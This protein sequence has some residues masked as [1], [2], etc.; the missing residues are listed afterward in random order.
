[1]AG[2]AR[3]S[4]SVVASI[5]LTLLTVTVFALSRNQGP[6]SAIQRYHESLYRLGFQKALDQI[7][8]GNAT[9]DAAEIRMSTVQ[10]AQDA[11]TTAF[12]RDIAQLLSQSKSVRT[13]QVHRSG[14]IAFLDVVYANNQGV[15][16]IRYAMQKGPNGWQ[17][18]TVETGRRTRLLMGF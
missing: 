8:N 16:T 12:H 9:G 13:A 2:S 10:S 7:A 4:S 3:W 17:I 6:E 18:D 15:M 14:R 5:L 1:M 11:A